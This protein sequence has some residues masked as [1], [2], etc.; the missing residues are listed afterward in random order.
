[1]S[2]TSSQ[3]I[4]LKTLVQTGLP[5]VSRPYQ[6]LAE[7]IGA[8]EIDVMGAINGWLEDGLIKRLGLVVKHRALGYQSNA[9][10][11]W[12]VPDTAIDAVGRNLANSAAVTLCYQRPRRPQWPYNLF[13]MIHGRSRKSVLSQL[14]NL[15]EQHQLQ[16]IP[17]DV[18]FSYKEFK[19]CGARYFKNPRD[20]EISDANKSSLNSMN[21]ATLIIGQN[22][23][24]FDGS[25]Q[26]V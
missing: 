25:I 24:N 26:R 6:Y 20:L 2:L 12:D 13:C 22:D 19:Q 21:S 14:D 1:M 15:I 4:H 10:V 17:K 16:S 7:E 11:V 5:L 23:K 9:M 3:K 18:L 8:T